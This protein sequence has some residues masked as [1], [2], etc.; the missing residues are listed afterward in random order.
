MYL[1][2]SAFVKWR[3]SQ[4]AYFCPSCCHLFEFIMNFPW[5]PAGCYQLVN[6]MA[7]VLFWYSTEF[8][9]QPCDF[10]LLWRQE[11]WEVF[12]IFLRAYDYQFS[13]TLKR[14]H[15]ANEAMTRKFM[16]ATSNFF[17]MFFRSCILVPFFLMWYFYAFWS[18]DCSLMGQWMEFV[19]C[20]HL[21]YGLNLCL[22][23]IKV[24]LPIW[25][26]RNALV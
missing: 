8:I 21:R 20:S 22:W 12:C 7:T 10:A 6:T 2:Q 14:L 25:P 9:L 24:S 5:S 26:F 15:V 1:N 4:T 3:I 16:D 17:L 19:T 13:R 11:E 18:E 23:C